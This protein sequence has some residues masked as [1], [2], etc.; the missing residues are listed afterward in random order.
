[1]FAFVAELQNARY[2]SAG[3]RL[4]GSPRPGQQDANCLSLLPY[5]S[6]SIENKG[7]A[8]PSAFRLGVVPS[9][10]P[11]RLRPPR[12][13]KLKHDD[14]TST[15]IKISTRKPFLQLTGL[16]SGEHDRRHGS[17]ERGADGAA[18]RGGRRSGSAH[19]RAC[20]DGSASVGGDGELHSCGKK[21][22][23]R[24][25][26]DEGR[27]RRRRSFSFLSRL[28]SAPFLFFCTDFCYNN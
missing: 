2:R 8:W 19:G 13:Q 17:E 27:D 20:R 11:R 3:M 10:S 22:R 26:R 15:R 6:S 28:L 7:N 14:G 16:R 24:R 23:Q 25:K 21:G 18:R 1:M 5:S 9:F 4:C 12:A